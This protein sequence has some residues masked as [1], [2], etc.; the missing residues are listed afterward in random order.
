MVAI[1]VN[2]AALEG[3]P[4]DKPVRG[5]LRILETT[6]LHMQILGYDYFADRVDLRA[7]LVQLTDQIVALRADPAVTCVLFDNGDFLQ[8]NPLADHLAAEIRKPARARQM[9]P[10]IGAFAALGYD[11][12]A[13]GNH[14]FNYGLPF[15]RA[16]LDGAPFGVVCANIDWQ[17]EP[18]C[19]E[20]W[21][22]LDR[23]IRCDDG[24]WRSIKLGVIGFTPPQITKWDHIALAGRINTADIVTTAR[25]LVPQIKAAGADLVIALCHSG[26]GNDHHIIGMQNAAV[27]LAAVAGLDV[28]LTGHTHDLFPNAAR[29]ASAFVDPLAGTLHG[30][31]AVAAGCFGAALGVID[32]DLLWQDSRWQIANHISRTVRAIKTP[33][34][35]PIA[36]R[37]R[38]VVHPDHAAT[39]A[40]IRQPVTQTK[41]PIHSYFATITADLPRAILAQALTDYGAQVLPALDLPLIAA[42]PPFRAGGRAGPSH[43]VDIKAGPVSLRDISAIYPFADPP[44][45]IRQSGAML[46]AW[47]EQAV[48]GYCQI[49][50]DRQD[51]VLKDPD[52]AIFT[53][54]A[55]I[56]LTYDIDLRA[57]PR[58]SANGAVINPDSARIGNLRYEGRLIEDGDWFAV[59]V[60]SYRAFGGGAYAAVANGNILHLSDRP[61]RDMLRD[62][63][64]RSPCVDMTAA[65][66]WRF[67]PIAGASAWFISAPAARAHLTGPIS[68][69]GAGDGGFDRYRLTF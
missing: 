23:R 4:Q 50:P 1:M 39:L 19:A 45:I 37:L 43:F 24:A 61:L 6:D 41:G 68:H 36:A 34:Q 12:V 21:V 55:L 28:I 18:A 5:K 63:L 48:S 66:V 67:V 26:I 13:L 64:Q 40:Q 11:A 69:I 15:L 3:S 22:M 53:C 57:K 29:D 32:L 62:Y 8:G 58:H 38:S 56:G 65:A 33:A 52:F 31:P 30:K 7:G 35:D 59:A 47:L 17:S 54:D 16:A 20:P 44:V 14:E 2:D 10:M 9:H 60:N 51:Q 42:V 49:W 25:A 46:R 27:P